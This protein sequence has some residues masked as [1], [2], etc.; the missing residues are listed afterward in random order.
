MTQ[1][2]QIIFSSSKELQH[3]FNDSIENGDKVLVHCQAGISRSATVVI[4]YIMRS[5]KIIV[6]RCL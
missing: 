1:N 6:S 5:K 3:L 4:A 2:L